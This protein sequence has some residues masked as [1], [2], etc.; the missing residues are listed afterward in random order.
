MTSNKQPK[1]QVASVQELGALIVDRVKTADKIL[2]AGVTLPDGYAWRIPD[3]RLSFWE[4]CPVRS[5]ASMGASI[6]IDRMATTGVSGEE[7]CSD[8][9]TIHAEIRLFMPTA[10]YRDGRKVRRY[11]QDSDAHFSA[12]LW[13]QTGPHWAFQSTT[14]LVDNEPFVYADA[15]DALCA[16][17]VARVNTALARA[18]L[19]V[20]QKHIE[21]AEE[22][23]A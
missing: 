19:R 14:H 6:Y 21:K 2:M 8:P 15:L 12:H 4:G 13:V 23:C 10:E 7:R 9:A 20:G 3:D 11:R 22:V 17:I 1:K 18:G 5:T 16:E